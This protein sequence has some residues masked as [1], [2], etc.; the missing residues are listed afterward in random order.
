MQKYSDFFKTLHDETGP[1]GHLGRGTHYSILRAVSFHDAEGTPLPKGQF[2]D[3]AVIWDEDH[4]T[5]VIEPI[6]EV[7]RRGLLSSF[8]MFGERKGFFTAVHDDFDPSGTRATF[9]QK[10]ISTICQSL[11]DP[12]PSEVVSVESPMNPII[13]D[14]H[15]K[16][17]LYLKNLNMLWQ[18]RPSPRLT[19]NPAFLKK[20][21]ELDF[22]VRSANCLHNDD[23]VYIGDLV[24]K[25]EGEILR[26]ANAG[27]KT[28][29]EIKEVLMQ[30]GLHLGMEVRGWRPSNIEE[31]A[32][33]FED[34][35]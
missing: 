14:D 2:K 31:L 22:S 1:T 20:V 30:M 13:S 32:K 12:W 29:D 17:S 15:Q 16:V 33:R 3:F 8:L 18:L 35:Y 21:D 24:Q 10:E 6:E 27:R 4:D 25:N 34:H 23:I 5:R 28:L 7:Y 26:M 9:C 11:S 19:F